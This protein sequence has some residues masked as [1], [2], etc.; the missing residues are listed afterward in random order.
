MGNVQGDGIVV[1]GHLKTL[2]NGTATLDAK[3][4]ATMGGNPWNYTL[5]MTTNAI[6]WDCSYSFNFGGTMTE[7]LLFENGQFPFYIFGFR[8]GTNL[9]PGRGP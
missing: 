5:D 4:Y 1:L 6:T 3:Y 2:G 8:A 9:E 7:M